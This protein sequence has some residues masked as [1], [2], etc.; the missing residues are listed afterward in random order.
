MDHDHFYPPATRELSEKR[1]KLAPEVG[2]KMYVDSKFEQLVP[3]NERGILELRHFDNGADKTAVAE[4]MLTEV[5][6]VL[7][8]SATRYPV[9]DE[10]I[11]SMAHHYSLENN[12]EYSQ[13]NPKEIEFG[14]ELIFQ[15]PNIDLIGIQDKLKFR[16]STNTIFSQ[17]LL[18]YVVK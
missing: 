3:L 4:F 18:N 7:K 2:E 11:G 5:I 12:I 14:K 15:I 9:F 17:S 6:E 8:T 13:Q 1:A 10:L 16:R